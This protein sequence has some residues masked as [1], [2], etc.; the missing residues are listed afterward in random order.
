MIWPSGPR[1]FIRV[2]SLQVLFGHLKIKKMYQSIKIAAYSILIGL[3]LKWIS[4][5]SLHY[6]LLVSP[7]FDR[8]ARVASQIYSKAASSLN[9]LSFPDHVMH[10]VMCSATWLATMLVLH[11]ITLAVCRCLVWLW[12]YAIVVSAIPSVMLIIISNIHPSYHIS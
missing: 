9:K 5:K 6:F 8:Q 11:G 1:L 4:T 2:V 3:V 12:L 7:I 10:H